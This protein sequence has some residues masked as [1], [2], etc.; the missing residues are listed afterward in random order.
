MTSDLTI[1]LQGRLL[2]VRFARPHDVLSWAIVGGGR[3]TAEAVAWWQVR[4]AELDEH[5]DAA[6][7]LRGRLEEH[8]LGDAVGLLTSTEVATYTD[9]ERSMD[10]LSARCIATVGMGNALRAGDPPWS[11]RPV[12]TINLLLR[13]SFAL[14][15]QALLETLALAAEARALAVREAEIASVETGLPAS[16]TGTDCIVVAAP[17]PVGGGEPLRYAGKHTVAGH[18]AGAA[19][20]EAVER[21]VRRRVGEQ[22]R[23]I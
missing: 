20:L 8:G 9:V 16:G 23:P 11:A 14:S 22:K 21:G 1:H 2:A 3:R 6:A 10:G 19:V 12:G 13:T 5:T 18:L 4:N 17:A 7:L 15:D